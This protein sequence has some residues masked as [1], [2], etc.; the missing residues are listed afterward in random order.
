MSSAA[1]AAAA[2]P[3][4]A[5]AA[6]APAAAAP[7]AAAPGPRLG[8]VDARLARLNRGELNYQGPAEPLQQYVPP[9]P[10]FEPQGYQLEEMIRKRRK[11]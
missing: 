4:P 1:A 7:A 3:A 5:P 8:V 10:P 9:P 6:A 2:A 11:T